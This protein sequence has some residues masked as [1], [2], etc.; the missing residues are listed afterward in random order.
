MISTRRAVGDN[1]RSACLSRTDVKDDWMTSSKND[2]GTGP[3]SRVQDTTV[4]FSWIFLTYKFEATTL[5]PYFLDCLID[6]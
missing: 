3:E 6:H 4:R 1:Q 5:H 2:T